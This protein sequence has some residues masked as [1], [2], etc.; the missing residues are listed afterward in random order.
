MHS[1]RLVM[2]AFRFLAS[3]L[4]VPA[5]ALALAAALVSPVERDPVARLDIA[6]PALQ[7][8]DDEIGQASASIAIFP[9]LTSPAPKT[10][11][12]GADQM[13]STTHAETAMRA[14]VAAARLDAQLTP[15]MRKYFGL[16]LYVSKAQEG[17]LAQ[18]MMVF[19]KTHGHLQLAY[20]W[21]AST[22]REQVEVNARGRHVLTATP[23]GYYEL[24][25]DRMYRRYRSFSWDQEMPHA[26]FFN[27]QRAGRP[28]GLAIHAAAGDDVAKLGS[29]ASAGCVHLSPDNAATLYALIRAGFRGRVPRLDVDRETGTSSNHGRFMHSRSGQIKTIDGYRVLVMIEDHSG[30]DEALL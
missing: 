22:G 16:F 12:A 19:K 14:E 21:L 1:F 8:Q 6:P 2:S 4:L 13:P 5:S 10:A 15:E 20:D 26:M 23:G 30:E 29:R 17:P 24:D 11:V 18:H 3:S 25:P 9:D 28:T 27:W 7:S